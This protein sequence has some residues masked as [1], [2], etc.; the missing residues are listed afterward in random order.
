MVGD[1]RQRWVTRDPGGCRQCATLH[2][3]LGRELGA[4]GL[5]SSDGERTKTPPARHLPHHPLRLQLTQQRRPGL[6]RDPEFSGERLRRRHRG[7]QQRLDRIRQPRPLVDRGGKPPAL[8]RDRRQ[9]VALAQGR[10]RA[11]G[12][13]VQEGERPGDRPSA[14]DRMDEL[15]RRSVAWWKPRLTPPVMFPAFRQIDEG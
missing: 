4:T 6:R 7:A 15:C 12:H 9:P 8:L 11:L 5:C 1:S 3:R 2:S 13:Q 10:P 14:A